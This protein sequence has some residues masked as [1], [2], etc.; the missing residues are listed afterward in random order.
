[1]TKLERNAT[2][3]LLHNADHCC[4]KQS[5]MVDGYDAKEKSRPAAEV[6]DENKGGL[7]KNVL[8][9]RKA[10]CLWTV[11]RYEVHLLM[12]TAT[13]RLQRLALPG[14]GQAGQNRPFAPPSRCHRK[15]ENPRKS[16]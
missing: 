5:I 15:Y 12:T 16:A 9:H 6:S 11:R 3:C 13:A 4:C 10:A 1:M 2:S 14:M 7:F 8:K